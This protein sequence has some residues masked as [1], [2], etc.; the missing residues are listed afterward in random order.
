MN[1]V[2][3]SR[4]AVAF[5]GLAAVTV[6]RYAT[7]ARRFIFSAH[8]AARRAAACGSYS[9]HCRGAIFFLTQLEKDTSAARQREQRGKEKEIFTI[10]GNHSFLWNNDY[11]NDREIILP[12]Y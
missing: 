3:L 4:C 7:S 10:G 12:L 8:G 2:I 9:A 1:R 5:P 11:T 6:Q